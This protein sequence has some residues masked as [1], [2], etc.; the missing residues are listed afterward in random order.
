MEEEKAQL[1]S[2]YAKLTRKNSKLVNGMIKMK[3]DFK[4]LQ[5]NLDSQTS[6]NEA[7]KNIIKLWE[8]RRKAAKESGHLTVEDV[9]VENLK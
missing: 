7:L 5:A 2:D 8:T 1:T 3:Q 6:E 9:L 4:D